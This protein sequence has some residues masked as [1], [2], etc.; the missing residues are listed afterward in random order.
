MRARTPPLNP[1]RTRAGAKPGQAIA[2]GARGAQRLRTH[3]RPRSG[4][5]AQRAIARSPKGGK[6]ASVVH[7]A[8]GMTH[9]GQTRCLRCYAYVNWPYDAVRALLHDRPVEVLRGATTS[10]AS[11][12][13]DLAGSM[14]V[15]VAGLE[16][17]VQVSM[18]VLAVRDDEGVAGLS[19]VTRVNLAWE[20]A[21]A[22]SLFPFMSAH[23]SAW[24]LTS[25]ETQIEIEGD[26]TPPLG[27]LGA[28]I[29][30]VVGHRIAEAAVRQFV[31][32]VVEQMRQEL[33]AKG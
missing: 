11:R 23:L 15:A 24:P 1:A 16:L 21:R 8:R 18:H 2:F 4:A 9:N 17:G 19:P 33:Q 31:D 28:A 10:A 7:P 20:A 27:A 29:D 5:D 32:D 12:A 14:R 13:K 30:A 25:T 22:P 3:A 6:L 26:Y